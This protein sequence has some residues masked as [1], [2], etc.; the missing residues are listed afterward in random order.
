[1]A[2][3]GGGG[4]KKKKEPQSEPLDTGTVGTAITCRPL[5]DSYTVSPLSWTI[6]NSH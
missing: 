3:I 4:D 5:G 2:K 1:M 6:L